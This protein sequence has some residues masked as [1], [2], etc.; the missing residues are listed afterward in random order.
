MATSS[1]EGRAVRE[2]WC[3]VQGG[4][5]IGLQAPG[6]DETQ[7]GM[8]K[9]AEGRAVR[10]PA[11]E[12]R[13]H[14]HRAADLPRPWIMLPRPVRSRA[15]SN[16]L[17]RSLLPS[18]IG[19][20]P[21]ATHH[22]IR[23]PEGVDQAIFKYC[24]EGRGW[25]EIAGRSFD[26][27]PGELMVVPP[28]QPHAYG[29]RPEHPWT[30]HWFHAVGEH[31][32]LLLGELGVS[33]EQPVVFLGN[34]VRLVALFQDLE[35]VLEEDYSAPKLLYASQLLGHLVGTMIHLRRSGVSEPPGAAARVSQSAAHMVERLDRPL[36]VSDLASLANLSPSHYSALFRRLTGHSPKSYFTRL[37]VDRAAA[38]LQS[39]DAS[40]KTIAAML[41]YDDALYFSRTFRAACG[42][43]PSGYRRRAVSPE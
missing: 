20:F 34:S 43:S 8:D 29:A 17:L 39:T 11:F 35:Q 26:V 30:V 22:K 13:G 4:G 27:G 33:A 6:M 28:R 31:L 3:G 21:D 7:I 42:I 40:V 41:G 16:P 36:C 2:R 37:R 12:Q 19:F 14:H 38:L 18:H 15:L 5:S 32:D 24:V 1:R 10:A 9:P 23:R 25:C